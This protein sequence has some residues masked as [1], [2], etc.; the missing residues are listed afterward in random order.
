MKN[1][2]QAPSPSSVCP[3]RQS[4]TSARF[5]MDLA[6]TYLDSKFS[7]VPIGILTSERKPDPPSIVLDNVQAS[8]VGIMVKSEQGNTLLGG[9]L[10]T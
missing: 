8:N 7:N 2:A 5:L 9:K 3:L 10:P 1:R 6:P 4:T